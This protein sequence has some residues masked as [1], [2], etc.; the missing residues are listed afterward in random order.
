VIA[1]SRQDNKW[2]SFNSSM[3]RTSYFLMMTINMMMIMMMTTRTTTMMKM[4]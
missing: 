4:S 1:V 3:A 2:A